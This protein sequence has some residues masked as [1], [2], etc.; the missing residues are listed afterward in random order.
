MSVTDGFRNCDIIY[1]PG[2]IVRN[3]TAPVQLCSKSKNVVNFKNFRKKDIVS[4]NS[5]KDLIPF[6]KDPYK[7]GDDRTTDYMREE[8]KRKQMEAVAEDL[9]NNEKAR[10]RAGPGT[11]LQALF[12]RR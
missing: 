9:F 11:S 5:F 8:R 7:E 6:S 2:L 10:K 1:N 12:A 4:G 3:I